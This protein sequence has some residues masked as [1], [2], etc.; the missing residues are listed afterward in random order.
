MSEQYWHSAHDWSEGVI[1]EENNT[2]SIAKTCQR[3]QL[4]ETIKYSWRNGKMERRIL[5]Y[6][7]QYMRKYHCEQRAKG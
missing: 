5:P 7:N 1:K 3:C 4:T 6:Q 2:V